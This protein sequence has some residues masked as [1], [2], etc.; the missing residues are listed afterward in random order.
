[1]ELLANSFAAMAGGKS[2]GRLEL[3]VRTGIPDTVTAG[4]QIKICAEGLGILAL[5]S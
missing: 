5:T 4:K 1:M 3:T 2:G